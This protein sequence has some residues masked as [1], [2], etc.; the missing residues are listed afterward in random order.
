[1][2]GCRFEWARNAAHFEA[3]LGGTAVSRICAILAVLVFS[4]FVLA[5]TVKLTSGGSVD[6]IVLQET[7]TYVTVLLGSQIMGYTRFEVESISKEARK[8][9]KTSARIP[10]YETIVIRLAGQ[11]WASELYQIPATVIGLGKLRNVPYKSQRAGGNYEVNVYGDP[12]APVGFE[13]GICGDLLSDVKAKNNCIKFICELLGDAA[14]S[15]I[16]KALTLEKDLAVRNGLTMEITPPTATD[17]Y[18]GW[19]VSVYDEAG[20][21]AARAKDS[22][23]DSIAVTKSSVLSSTK[24]DIG[25]TRTKRDTSNS[26]E[27]DNDIVRRSS[28]SADDIKQAR[29]TKKD[30]PKVE[31]SSSGD[32]RVYV[33]GYTRKDGT[34]VEP[35]YRSKPAKK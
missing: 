20:L 5:D 26:S 27:M 6:C 17:A 21:D 13:I 1:V 22:E 31:S 30:S 34:Y 11:P 28:W 24:T 32:D 15:A 9:T 3:L 16:L 8:D 29:T 10:N 7:K 35:Y 25:P 2:W 33:R 18:G 4:P 14:D 19:W 23:M 12:D